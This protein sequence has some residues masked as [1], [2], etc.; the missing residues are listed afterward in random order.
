[1]IEIA[2]FRSSEGIRNSDPQCRD[3]SKNKNPGAINRG[4]TL[5]GVF[6]MRFS[7]SIFTL[8]DF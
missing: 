5:S 8:F 7:V 4:N 2:R 6:E 1:M 3:R